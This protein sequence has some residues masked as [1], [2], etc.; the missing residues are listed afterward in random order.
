MILFN[1]FGDIYEYQKWVNMQRVNRQVN[2]IL[3][4]LENKSIGFLRAS[5]VVYLKPKLN[6][7]MCLR[8]KV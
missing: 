5:T 8:F 7:H 6:L 1:D 4:V 3:Q 2:C